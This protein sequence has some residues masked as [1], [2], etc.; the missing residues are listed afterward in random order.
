MSHLSVSEAARKL[1]ANPR[2]ISDLFYRRELRD[3]L[4]PIVAG[5][6]LIPPDY[7]EMVRM[8][9]R[10]HGRP[11]TPSDEKKAAGHGVAGAA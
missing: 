5:R 4:C 9:L 8:V 11:V 7:L 1:G 3:D 10:R 6:R 2:D